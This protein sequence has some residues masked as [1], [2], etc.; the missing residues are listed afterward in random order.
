MANRRRPR[1]LSISL[2]EREYRFLEMLAAENEETLAAQLRMVLRSHPRWKGFEY[3][4]A[5]EDEE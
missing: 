1:R 5:D 2:S 3:A 4:G